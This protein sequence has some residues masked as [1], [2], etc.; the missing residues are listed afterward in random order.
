MFLLVGILVG[1][2]AEP[3]DY[4]KDVEPIFQKHCV[5]CHG[6]DE[7]ESDLR[8]DRRS[9]LLRGGES[10]EPS[11]LPGKGSESFLIRVVAGKVPDLAMPPKGKKLSDREVGLLRTWI[12]EGAKTPADVSDNETIAKSNHWS[13]QP[14]ASVTPPRL[15]SDFIANPIDAFVLR[16]LTEQKLRPSKAADRRT[17]IRRLYLVLHG[18]P[19]T[20]EQ[21]QR[22]L[23]DASSDAWPSAVDAALKSPRYGERWARHWLDLVRFGETQ[24]FETNR[25]RPHA[26]PFRDY[27]I[28]SL[29]DDKPYNQF[30]REQIAGDAV[31]EPIGTGFLVAG[32]H[33]IVKG[34]GNLAAVQRMNELDDMINATGTTFLGLTLGCARCHNHKFDPI[35]QTDYY[36]LQAVFAGVRHGDAALPISTENQKQIDV[37]HG[38]VAQLTRNLTPFLKRN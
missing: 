15:N 3:V 38:E 6:P 12:N 30:G 10:G 17:L 11:I 26:W 36:A 23:D 32:P 18:L 25:E 4:Q 31:D 16:K 1:D 21:I 20:R 19:P 35:T 37:L 14:V 7:Q 2:A 9:S 13:F 29:N 27:V 34:G 33:D 24:G 5:K 28:R 22:F 8:L